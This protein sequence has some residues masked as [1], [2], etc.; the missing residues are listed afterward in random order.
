[1][2]AVEARGTGDWLQT[3]R[4]VRG[5]RWGGEEIGNGPRRGRLRRW[6]ARVE[7]RLGVAAV[8]AG[9]LGGGR[10]AG[11]CGRANRAGLARPLQGWRSMVGLEV[12]P[13]TGQ[14]IGWV[15]RS[16]VRDRVGRDSRGW[17]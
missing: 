2:R 7:L 17:C 13:E 3:R 11:V 4:I 14:G 12:G 6:R 1:M 5:L 16:R 10:E 8:V 15:A 9:D